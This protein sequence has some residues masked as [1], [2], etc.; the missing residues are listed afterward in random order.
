[1][2]TACT[3]RLSLCSP[4][5][6]STTRNYAISVKAPKPLTGKK[7]PRVF[8]DKKAFQYNWYSSILKANTTFPILILHHHD[9]TAQRLKKLRGDITAAAQKMQ[10]SLSSPGPHPMPVAP[11]Q[12]T[13]TVVRT[14]IFGA[15]LRDLPDVNLAEVER[16]IN[17]KAGQFAVLS[18]SSLH[19]PQIGAILRAMDRSVPPKPPKTEEEIK[20]ALEA[21]QT[22]PV[23]PGRR[24]KRVRQVRIP[25]LTVMGAI[26]ENRVLL[27]KDVQDVSKLPTLDTLRAQIVGLL[28]APAAQL[29]A[30]LSEA[31]GGKLARTLEGL[32][33]GLE[34][35]SENSSVDPG[36]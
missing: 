36:A 16:M 11:V 27:P 30:V 24:I 12:P 18:L 7:M 17:S 4:R 6:P 25:E 1:M 29:A 9:F 20:Q 22:D 28:S 10:P 34:E 31:S 32:K 15:A 21:K 26:I 8:K 5:I 19:P 3:Y 13:L 35:G 23:Q 2:Q 14:S 33:K